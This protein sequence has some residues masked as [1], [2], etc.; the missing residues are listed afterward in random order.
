VIRGYGLGHSASID[1]LRRKKRR[2]AEVVILVLSHSIL[3]NIFSVLNFEEKYPHTHTYTHTQ[4]TPE[5]LNNGIQMNSDKNIYI[6]SIQV[7]Y[8]GGLVGLSSPPG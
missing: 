6:L 4:I 2:G 3:K 7:L 1:S 5:Y 8:A